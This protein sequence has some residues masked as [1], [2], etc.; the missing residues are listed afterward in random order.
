MSI[1]GKLAEFLLELVAMPPVQAPQRVHVLLDPKFFKLNGA[2]TVVQRDQRPYWQQRSWSRN[3]PAFYGYFRTQH[4]SWEG[5]AE[6][7]PSGRLD[8][9][10]RD[11]PELLRFHHH[12][13]C[14]SKQKHGWYSIHHT[15]MS[16]LSAEILAIETI[17]MECH[18]HGDNSMSKAN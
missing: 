4:G 10:I 8:L 13:S 9:Y 16:D 1:L 7:S 15:K 17:L 6:Q 12:W 5:K 2:T 18:S 3:G 11:P 14:F